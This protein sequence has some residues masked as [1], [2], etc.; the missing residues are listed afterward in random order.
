[1][2]LF[3]IQ[4][5]EAAPL[6][7]AFETNGVIGVSP[8]D[9]RFIRHRVQTEPGSAG[10]PVFNADWDLIGMH[11]GNRHPDGT[12]TSLEANAKGERLAIAMSAIAED[13]KRKGFDLSGGRRRS[14][15]ATVVQPG[16]R[17]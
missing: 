2:P 17:H 12:P 1:M 13:L 14:T 3:I 11:Q 5:P 15:G 8:D 9:R 6:K 10:S 7:L 4:H 16:L